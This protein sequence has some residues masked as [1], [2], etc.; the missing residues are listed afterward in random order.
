MTKTFRPYEPDQMLLLP[1][2]LREWLPQDHLVYFLSD[3]VE[4]LD[5]SAIH[6]G[7]PEA[8]GYPPYHPL[9]MVKLLLYG[10]ARGLYSSR[11]L[12]RSCEED[13]A[14]RVLCAGSRPDFR[15][16][17][18]FRK[19]HL[20]AL[21]ELFLQGLRL[22]QRAGLVKLGHVAIDGTKIKAN[23]SKHKAMSYARMQQEEVR[24]KAE[25]EGLLKQSEAADAAEDAQYGAE[26]RGDEVPKELAH[27]TSRLKKIQEAKAALEEEAR[28]AAEEEGAPEGEAPEP[29]AK[30]QKNFTDPESRILYSS[31]KTFVQGYNAQA[32]VDH[33]SQVIV[34]AEVVRAANDKGQLTPMVRAAVENLEETPLA[35]SADAGY[36]VEAEVEALGRDEAVLYVAPE[37][38][39]H[40]AWKE[41]KVLPLPVPEALCGKEKMRYLLKTQEGRAEYD[42]RK[43]TVEPVFGQIKGARGFR[44]FLLRGLKQVR[45]EWKML[46]TVH[47]LLKLFR[48]GRHL[49]ALA[50]A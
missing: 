36:W 24:L 34:A 45:A 7:Y 41:Q 48:A 49:P 3:V 31:E 15:T 5:L 2:D 20:A 18:D 39:R 46:C 12:A 1:P 8:R 21:S 13:V 6:A 30:A 27:R 32:A 19:R 33:A 29:R 42:K 17:S 40:G 14:F 37:K 50:A 44:Q 38:I 22:C 16:I 43:V 25:I 23:A 47:N 10:Y 11:T 35:F 28:V 9:L 4:A 26:K